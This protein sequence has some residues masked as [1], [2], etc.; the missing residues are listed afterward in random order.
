MIVSLTRV[1]VAAAAVLH[2]GL[3]AAERARIRAAAAATA[4]T[5]AREALL[6]S[7]QTDVDRDSLHRVV[8]RA[9]A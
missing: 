9:L 7:A 4:A 8:V 5:H 6:A 2:A 1:R 3:D